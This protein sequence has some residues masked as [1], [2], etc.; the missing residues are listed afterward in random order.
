MRVWSGQ[1]AKIL[2]LFWFALN[3]ALAHGAKNSALFVQRKEDEFLL[4]PY[5]REITGGLLNVIFDQRKVDQRE[6]RAA[7]AGEWLE[8]GDAFTMKDRTGVYVQMNE[9]MQWVGGGDLDGRIHDSHW[10]T[11]K[12]AYEMTIQRGW[13]KVW[14][15]P[16][17]F[18]D[19]LVVNTRMTKLSAEN[20]VFWLMSTPIKTEVYLLSGVV[21]IQGKECMAGQY[22]VVAEAHPG[23][24]RISK[25]WSLLDLEK[26]AATRYPN[27]VKLSQKANEDWQSGKSSKVYAELREKG[28]VKSDRFFPNDSS[29]K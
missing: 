14:L 1:S 6:K 9:S 24:L 11:T 18:S 16:G 23:E 12:T 26:Q 17:E 22:C 28:W 13:M 2:I 25:E 10:V 27:L 3:G 8:F 20:A 21:K 19:S 7:H 5:L 29:K 4:P 15:K